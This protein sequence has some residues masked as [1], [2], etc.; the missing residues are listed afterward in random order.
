LRT[1]SNRVTKLR[2][3]GSVVEVR[4]P[5]LGRIWTTTTQET[6]DCV[7]KDSEAFSMRREDGYIAGVRWWMPSIVRTLANHT[8]SMDE[9]D[10]R[11]LRDIVDEP[12]RRRTILEMEPRIL[13]IADLPGSHT[14]ARDTAP[15][16]RCHSQHR[17]RGYPRKVQ[18]G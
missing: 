11:R 17:G 1:D 12:F 10:H 15:A 14:Y 7:L 4:F 16:H 5:T 3:A 18:P 6:A 9:P 8:L 13:A 2:S